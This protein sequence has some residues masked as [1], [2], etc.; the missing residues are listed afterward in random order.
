MRTNLNPKFWGRDGWSFLKSCAVACDEETFSHYLALVNLI[1]D[2]LPCERCRHHAREYIRDNPPREASELV[3]WFERF[4][5]AVRQRKEDDGGTNIKKEGPEVL[6][7]LGLG[8]LLSLLA[9]CC[10]S[11]LLCISRRLR[12]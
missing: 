7:Y 8:V 5:E 4:E 11:V 3:G 1:P 2:V 10:I 9:L 12:F 6:A